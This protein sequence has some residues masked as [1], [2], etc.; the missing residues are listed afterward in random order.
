[1]KVKKVGI[2]NLYVVEHIHGGDCGDGNVSFYLVKSKTEPTE[3]Q[4][5]EVCQIHYEPE[6]EVFAESIEIYPATA[7]VLPGGDHRRCRL[8]RG[9]SPIPGGISKARNLNP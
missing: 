1:M 2:P 3:E 5:I 4:V 8:S 7:Y 6:S 9:R